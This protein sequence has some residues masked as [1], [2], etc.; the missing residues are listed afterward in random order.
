MN[1]VSDAHLALVQYPWYHDHKVQ[2]SAVENATGPQ[3]V[4]IEKES[5]MC[6]VKMSRAGA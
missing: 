6:V 2:C 3:Q 1:N 4:M 5:N